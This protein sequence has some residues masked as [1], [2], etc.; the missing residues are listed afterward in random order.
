MHL[1]WLAGWLGHIIIPTPTAFLIRKMQ[2]HVPRFACP[3]QLLEHQMKAKAWKTICKITSRAAGRRGVIWLPRGGWAGV[4]RCKPTTFISSFLS[5]ARGR[6]AAR[7]PERNLSV[8]KAERDKSCEAREASPATGAW[9]FI[10]TLLSVSWN[11]KRGATSL[12][13]PPPSPATT[14]GNTAWKQAP[15]PPVSLPLQESH[16]AMATGGMETLK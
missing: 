2:T 7:W 16:S 4:G 9:G 3:T 5:R 12:P 10:F 14:R 15:S 13:S 6:Q 1:D 11:V 8:P